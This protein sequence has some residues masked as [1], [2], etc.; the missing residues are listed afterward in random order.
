MNKQNPLR[1]LF[2]SLA[3][4]LSLPMLAALVKI[5]GINYELNAKS[6]QATVMWKISGKYSGEVVIPESVEFNGISHSVTSI[7]SSA[8]SECSGLTSVTIPNSVTR[9][10]NYAFSYCSGLT[11]VTIGSGV[12]SIGS[13]AFSDCPELLDV[14]CYAENVPSTQRNAFNG[15][16]LKYITLHVPDAS[17]DSYMATAPWSS[18]GKIVALTEDETG[19]NELKGEKG[20]ENSA[21]YD[22]SGRRVQKGQKGVFIQNGK[23]MVR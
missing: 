9:I 22:L 10:G 2:L 14:Y 18:F 21:L 20:T 19:I 3:V 13:G 5:D 7:G 1:A 12:E 16:N 17:I 4:L 11:S 15:S 23:V 8:F 6:K